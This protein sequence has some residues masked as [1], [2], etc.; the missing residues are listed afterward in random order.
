[1]QIQEVFCPKSEEKVFVNFWFP[2]PPLPPYVATGASYILCLTRSLVNRIAAVTFAQV[3]TQRWII[4]IKNANTYSK[5]TFVCFLNCV[6]RVKIWE[7]EGK[8]RFVC[9]MRQKVCFKTHS[10]G[11]WPLVMSQ[12]GLYTLLTLHP[13]LKIIPWQLLCF[14]HFSNIQFWAKMRSYLWYNIYIPKTKN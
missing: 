3:L 14:H 6:Y 1:M 10:S 12:D 13:L 4:Y 8:K 5:F 2:P 11:Q 9:F 7:M